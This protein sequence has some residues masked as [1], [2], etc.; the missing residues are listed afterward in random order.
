LRP[1]QEHGLDNVG[2]LA[3][4]KLNGTYP[5]HFMDQSPLNAD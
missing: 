3:E 2:Q 5:A 1:P 4:F